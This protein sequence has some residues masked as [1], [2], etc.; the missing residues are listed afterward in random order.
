MRFDVRRSVGKEVV[1]GEGGGGLAR[2]G[3]V[4]RGEGVFGEEGGGSARDSEV[5]RR[6]LG[7]VTSDL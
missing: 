5:W 1:F 6:N 7:L 4:W 2:Q 3:L